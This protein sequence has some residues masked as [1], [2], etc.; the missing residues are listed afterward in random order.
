MKQ[1]SRQ[2]KKK[3]FK[4]T[5]MEKKSCLRDMKK[6]DAASQSAEK[7]KIASREEKSEK[8]KQM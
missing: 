6:Y 5:C 1:Y 2:A 7:I 4:A 8:A 3:N